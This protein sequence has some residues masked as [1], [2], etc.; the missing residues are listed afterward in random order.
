MP[1]LTSNVSTLNIMIKSEFI[2]HFFENIPFIITFGM[3]IFGDTVDKN[4]VIKLRK[5]SY[6][7]WVLLFICFT[8]IWVEVGS[9]AYND[10]MEGAHQLV[11]SYFICVCAAAAYVSKIR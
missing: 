9:G 8:I 2:Q 3:M 6:K 5:H 1:L 4:H 10:I 7:I 11:G